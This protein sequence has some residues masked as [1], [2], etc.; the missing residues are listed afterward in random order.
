MR[1]SLSLDE[2][3]ALVRLDASQI[4]EWAAARLID[5]DGDG[6]FDDLDLLRLMAIRHYEPLGYD[7]ERLA[8]ALASG[9]VEPFLGEYIYPR[10][11]QLTVE[12]AA[13]RTGIDPEMLADLL[14]ALGW[15]RPGFLE[16]DLRMLEGFK[17]IEESGMPREALLEGARVFGDT[18]RRLAETLVR[19][20]HV[21]IHERLLEEGLS[22]DEV[23]RRIHGLQEAAQA[24]LDG[25][26]ERVFHEHLLQADIEDAYVHLVD[27]DPVGGRGAVDAT[28]VFIDVE[29]FTRLTET[30]GDEVAVD[31][32]TRVDSLARALALER[33]GK[34]VK[35][36]GDAL[37]LAFRQPSDAASFAGALHDGTGR[38][39]LIPGLRVGMHCGPAIY[40][41]GDYIGATVN[42]ASRVTDTATAGQTVLTEAVAERLDDSAPVEPLGVRVLRG[43]ERP[44]ALYRL[45]H[46]EERRDPACGRSVAAPP[47]ARLRK[48]DDEL[49]FC[50]EECLRDFL[51]GLPAT[52]RQGAGPDARAD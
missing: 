36:I 3:A 15:A 5:P 40:R 12:Q 31:L 38:D 44:V 49:W 8:K 52:T 32:M 17:L 43:A 16:K 29:S 14:T 42:L 11:T 2:L 9:E 51:A 37:M 7:P 27:T 25:I 24:I 6:R 20:V 33:D 35:A 46:P 39:S 1:T 45:T 19:L 26:I 50:S 23:I 48:D 10:E 22:E 13:E 21:H 41:A 47:T 30:E 4:T 18:L 34:V 28:I